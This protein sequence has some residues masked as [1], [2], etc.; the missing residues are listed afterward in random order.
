M[1]KSGKRQVCQVS[2]PPS[3]VPS[4]LRGA[5][6]RTSRTRLGELVGAEVAFLVL[7]AIAT[8]T[9]LVSPRRCDSLCLLHRHCVVMIAAGTVHMGRLVVLGRHEAFHTTTAASGPSL[10]A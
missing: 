2:V 1:R 10:T 9:R 8:P 7:L 3:A 5:K 6:W 4:R